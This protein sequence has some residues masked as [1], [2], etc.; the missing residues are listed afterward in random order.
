M[1]GMW[2][3]FEKGGGSLRRF[4]GSDYDSTVGQLLYVKRTF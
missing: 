2:L 1:T 4:G 3:N